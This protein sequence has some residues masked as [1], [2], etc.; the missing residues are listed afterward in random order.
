MNAM[1]RMARNVLNYSRAHSRKVKK[2]VVSLSE[3]IDKAWSSHGFEVAERG[4]QLKRDREA[5]PT[6][7]ADPFLLHMIIANFFSRGL[8]YIQ[9]PNLFL[10]ISASEING[11]CTRFELTCPQ[12]SLENEEIMET[13]RILT[14]EVDAESNAGKVNADNLGLYLCA[15]AISRHGGQV[16]VSVDGSGNVTFWFELPAATVA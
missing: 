6:V 8:S 16:D 10:K 11:N 5:M 9:N 13:S 4:V 2:E 3:I 12:V 14:R 1:D 7:Y 15:M